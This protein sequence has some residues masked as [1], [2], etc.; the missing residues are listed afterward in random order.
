MIDL[1]YNML[2]F[3]IA[4]TDVIIIPEQHLYHKAIIT[5]PEMVAD[6]A[7]ICTEILQLLQKSHNPTVIFMGD[8]V[9]RGIKNTEDAYPIEDF[10]RAVSL[11]TNGRVF[12]VVGNHELTYRRNNPFWGVAMIQ[13]NYIK[14]IVKQTYSIEHPLIGVVDDIIIGD[15]QYSFGHYGRVYGGSY[16]SPDK[17]KYITLL[18][19]NSLLTNEITQYMKN[20]GNDLQEQ[21]LKMR[22]LRQEGS[23]PLTTLLKYVYVGHL[24]KAHGVFNVEEN[25]CGLKFK[26]YLRYLA[27]LGRTNHGEYTDDLERQLPIHVIRDGKFVEEKFHTILLTSREVSVDER[28]VLENREGYERQKQVR[29]LKKVTSQTMDLIN[30]VEDFIKDDPTLLDWFNRAGRNE[31][32]PELIKV[33]NKYGG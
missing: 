27:S 10:F 13:S 31:I 33:I 9:H 32:Q 7:K 22:E 30:A 17:V 18:T 6:N 2:D 8:I 1:G 11:Y 5:V 21:Y 26:F 20:K 23:L 19:H 16:S 28:V 12:S 4:D 24:H 3:N 14:S 29:E 15:M 25:I